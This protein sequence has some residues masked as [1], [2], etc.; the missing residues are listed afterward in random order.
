MTQ[1]QDQ[2][3]ALA[4]MMQSAVLINQ[5]ANGESINQAAYDCSLDSLFTLKAQS[6]EDI[7][8][9]GDGLINGLKTLKSY[10]TGDSGAPDRQIAYY[11]LS[12]IKL[13]AKMMKDHDLVETIQSGFETIQQQARDF[14]LSQSAKAH[15][16]DGLY[17][18]T[19]S[20]IKPRIIVQGDQT[21]LSHSDTTSKVRTLLF[22]GIRAAVLW[23]Q[24][25]GSRLKLLF[26]RKKYIEQAELLLERF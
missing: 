25:G 16:V 7:F 11:V 13:E 5:L 22:A 14:D 2:T 15:K 26:S 3:L 20:N 9:Y 12:M 4:S 19:I 17:Q 8:G 18:N 23:R 6:T 24:K 21:H 1:L 10:M